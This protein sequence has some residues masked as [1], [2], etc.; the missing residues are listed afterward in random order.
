VVVAYWISSA[1]SSR[2]TTA[3]RRQRQVLAN[4]KGGAV[5]LRG[6][7][8]VVAD[9]VHDVTKPAQHAGAARLEG[10]FEGRGVAQQGV[11]GR[12]SASQCVDGEAGPLNIVPIPVLP[13]EVI[14]QPAG[15]SAGSE[16]D[17][18]ESAV[19]R[20]EL[21]RRVGEALVLRRRQ[22]LVGACEDEGAVSRQPGRLP[23]HRPSLGQRQ[24]ES[25]RE[26]GDRRDRHRLAVLDRRQSRA[27]VLRH[28]P[29]GAA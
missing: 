1:T 13:L 6:H 26:A 19:R 2:A 7:A 9:V 24:R 16:V 5:G 23:R 8:P 12:Q 20:V 22:V 10:S 4:G 25:L 14:D 28:H 27:L 11:G 18:A 15:S 21:P 29:T 3:P 17:L